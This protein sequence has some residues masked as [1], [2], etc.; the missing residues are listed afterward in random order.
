MVKNAW[1]NKSKQKQLQKK[2]MQKSETNKPYNNRT[3]I[4][5]LTREKKFVIFIQKTIHK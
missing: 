4:S 2:D 5:K 1:P 3:K